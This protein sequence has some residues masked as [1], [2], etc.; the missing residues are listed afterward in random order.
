MVVG[1]NLNSGGHLQQLMKGVYENDSL[2]R[3]DLSDNQ[4]GDHEGLIIVRYLKLQSEKRE[5]AIWMT[6]LRH[7]EQGAREK[8]PDERIANIVQSS[9]DQSLRV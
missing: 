8:S 5:N 1:C 9:Q 4:I 6:G 3:L 2:V 7:S